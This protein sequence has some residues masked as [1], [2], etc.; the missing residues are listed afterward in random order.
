MKTLL[1]ALAL[2][3]AALN[4]RAQVVTNVTIKIT[5]VDGNGT[6]SVNLNANANHVTGLNLAW[7]RNK[8]ANGTNAPTFLNFVRQEVTDQF[9][10]YVT[11]STQFQ[12]QTNKLDTISTQLPALYPTMSAA[13]QNALA[14]IW[15]KYAP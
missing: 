15:K 14:A 3:T 4:A 2:F 10:P 7:E 5:V 13:D 8:L 11:A 6:N 9:S 1:I 12:L